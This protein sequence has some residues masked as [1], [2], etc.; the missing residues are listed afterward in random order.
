MRNPLPGYVGGFM[1]DFASILDS[2]AKG[3]SFFSTIFR[4]VHPIPICGK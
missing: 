1:Q 4:M 3:I 2:I